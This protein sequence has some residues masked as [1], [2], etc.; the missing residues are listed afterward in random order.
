MNAL[1]VVEDK[2]MLDV[3]AR[4]DEHEVEVVATA[5]DLIRDLSRQL[6]E[7]KVRLEGSVIARMQADNATKLFTLNSA[8]KDI[9][10][11]L[12]SGPMECKAKDADIVYGQHGFDPQEI[13]L[14]VFKPAWVRA[15][16]AR[17]FGGEK[18]LLIDELFTP[19]KP[20]LDI[21]TAGEK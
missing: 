7:Q 8:G 3:I 21:K 20:S 14:Y 19:G 9:V 5:I 10:V 12:K 11:T 17:K 13:G 2:T 18:Q 15:K 16:E 1:A 4:P 6:Y